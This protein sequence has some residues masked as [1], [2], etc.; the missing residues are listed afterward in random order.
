MAVPLARPWCALLQ[1]SLGSGGLICVFATHCPSVGVTKKWITSVILIH[2]EDILQ[3]LVPRQQ[4]GFSKHRCI[5]DPIFNSRAP[6]A[7]H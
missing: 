1:T 2:L 5:W 4:K 7:Q 3:K 6:W